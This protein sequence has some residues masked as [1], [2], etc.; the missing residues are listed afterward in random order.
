MQNAFG[1]SEEN[2]IPIFEWERPG[3]P[4]NIREIN[5]GLPRKKI[6]YTDIEKIDEIKETKTNDK[7]KITV[8][9]VYDEFKAFKKTKKYKDLVQSGAKVVFKAKKGENTIETKETDFHKIL[10]AL[11][12]KEKNTTL[13]KLFEQVVNNKIINEDDIFITSNK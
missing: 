10:Y 8:S 13:Y 2:I 5:L 1:E 9:G 11:V 12:L 7:I 6:I 3:K 4:Y